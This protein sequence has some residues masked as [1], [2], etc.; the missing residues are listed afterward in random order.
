MSETERLLEGENVTKQFGGFTAVDDV[1]F[2]IRRGEIVGLIGPNGAGKS[3]LFNC[4]T[5][6]MEPEAGN[7]RFD[8]DDITARPEHRIAQSGLIRL[9]QEVRVYD[10]MT[11]YE[12][13]LV[14]RDHS[15]ESAVDMFRQYDD[16]THRRA[17]ELLREIDLWDMRTDLAGTLSYGQQKLVEFA[18]TLMADP[19]L[20]L[21]DEPAGGINPTMIQHMLQYINDANQKR[22]KTLFVI[23]HN[24]DVIMEISDRIYVMGSGDVIAEGEPA[25]IRQNKRVRGAYLG[26]Q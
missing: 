21:L 6:A 8:G 18:M 23:E 26:G 10:D 25:E 11:L 9:F 20:L 3:T 5:G 12:N 16:E 24:M 14:S 15:T 17:E 19:E 13:V 4:I 2:E 7:I 22:N 1:D